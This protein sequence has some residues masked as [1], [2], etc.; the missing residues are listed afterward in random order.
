M[1][2]RDH[3]NNH[4]LRNPHIRLSHVSL[5][6]LPLFCLQ[7]GDDL[8]DCDHCLL[9]TIWPSV[10]T[11]VS[12]MLC[13]YTMI[14]SLTYIPI[15]IGYLNGLV[16]YHWL[17]RSSRGSSDMTFYLKILTIILCKTKLVFIHIYTFTWL[18]RLDWSHVLGKINVFLLNDTVL[19]SV[20]M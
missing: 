9:C 2:E 15:A 17:P 1:F 8:C 4:L 18:C 11:C 6:P 13:K 7:N 12:P 16:C 3:T 20:T 5:A 19:R 10:S 14:P